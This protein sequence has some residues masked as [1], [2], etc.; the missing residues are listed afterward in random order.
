R[1]ATTYRRLMPAPL[2]RVLG[3]ALA[4]RP[5]STTNGLR[6]RAALLAGAGAGPAAE[7]FV[8]DRALRPLR[9]TVYEP[10]LLGALGS[11]HPDRL[12]DVAWS[13]AV[14][15]DDVDRALYGDLTT[16]LPDQL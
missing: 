8:Y 9:S 12:Y 6:R 1:A 15:T 11:W 14:A 7:A 13:R 10:S 16:Y 3:E 4:E 2:R 5:G